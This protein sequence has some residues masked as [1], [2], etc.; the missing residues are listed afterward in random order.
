MW[1]LEEIASYERMF[2]WYLLVVANSGDKAE[3]ESSSY[4]F[5]LVLA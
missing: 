4:G 1:L 5:R 3:R 2:N